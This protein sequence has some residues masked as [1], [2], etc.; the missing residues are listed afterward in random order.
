MKQLCRKCLISE[1]D[2]DEYLE[3]LK[4]YIAS[5]PYDMRVSNEVYEKRLSLCRECGELSDGMCAQCGCYV[6]LRA[7]KPAMHCPGEKGSDIKW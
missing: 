1:L 6:E 2:Y 7:L 3:N 5:V 4:S